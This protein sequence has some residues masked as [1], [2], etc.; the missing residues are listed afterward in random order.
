M[1]SSCQF[2][3]V[4][5][6]STLIPNR[7]RQGDRDSKLRSGAPWKA[8]GEGV[9][10]SP[11]AFNQPSQVALD[12]FVTCAKVRFWKNR[13][14][15]GSPIFVEGVPHAGDLSEE[16][17]PDQQEAGSQGPKS[18]LGLQ[19][20]VVSGLKVFSICYKINKASI[21]MPTA[22]VGTVLLTSRGRG[23]GRRE[24]I[25]KFEWLREQIIKR[26]GKVATP[27]HKND[28]SGQ[29]NSTRIERSARR[30]L[31]GGARKLGWQAEECVGA[32]DHPGQEIRTCRDCLVTPPGTGLLQ[33]PGASPVRER[34]HRRLQHIQ[35]HQTPLRDQRGKG[36]AAQVCQLLVAAVED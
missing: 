26:G 25:T 6:T 23:L 31:R 2:Q 11:I 35:A 16:P 5:A 7:I 32:S 20:R 15:F 12:Q 34:G 36:R 17:G 27:E 24:L 28:N 1:P 3:S 8:E 30:L 21:I 10:W 9:H 29:V 13:C 22:V 4:R 18:D 14:P 19:V 33:E